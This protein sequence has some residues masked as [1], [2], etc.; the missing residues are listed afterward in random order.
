MKEFNVDSANQMIVKQLK[1][2]NECIA[3]RGRPSLAGI[4]LHPHPGGGGKHPL[5]FTYTFDQFELV[6]PCGGQVL[7]RCR[8][9]TG[10]LLN[11]PTHQGRQRLLLLFN[12]GI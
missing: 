8:G 10:H 6:T 5:L 11:R 7:D 2:E 1:V 4:F 3:T 12:V 9:S